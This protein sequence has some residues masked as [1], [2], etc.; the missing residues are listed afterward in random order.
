MTIFHVE[1]ISSKLLCL[2]VNSNNIESKILKNIRIEF[3]IRC[4][5]HGYNTISMIFWAIVTLLDGLCFQSVFLHEVLLRNRNSLHVHKL[6]TCVLQ[7]N[8]SLPFYILRI[9]LFFG[10]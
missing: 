1:K 7:P 4:I 10:G 2:F 6:G 9:H 3:Y 8:S 5:V